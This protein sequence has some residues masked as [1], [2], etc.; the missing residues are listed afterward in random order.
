MAQSQPASARDAVR[1][2]VPGL[3]GIVLTISTLFIT[4]L[5]ITRERERG[6]MENLLAMPVRPIEVMLAKIVPYVVIGYVQAALIM[7]VAAAVFGLPLR[8]SLLLLILALG[9]FIA[10]NLALGLTFSTIATNQMQAIQMAQFTLL[11]SFLLSG[12]MFPFKGMPVWAQWAGEIFPVTHILRIVRGILLK[13]NSF[14]EIAPELWPIA[15]FTLAIALVATWS[16]RE[17]LD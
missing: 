13:G 16:Y 9:L 5:S 14:A 4:T 10:S 11:P 17:T 3:I 2:I 12:F 8:G 6:T 15:V 7:A 1:N